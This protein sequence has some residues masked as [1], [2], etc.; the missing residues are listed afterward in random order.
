MDENTEVKLEM[1]IIFITITAIAFFFIVIPL[2]TATF[3]TASSWGSQTPIPTPTPKPLPGQSIEDA[4]KTQTPTPSPTSH[5]VDAPHPTP[6]PTASVVPHRTPV[7]APSYI[8]RLDIDRVTQMTNQ[9]SYVDQ[10]TKYIF[11][12]TLNTRTYQNILKSDFSVYEGSEEEGFEK[13]LNFGGG[14]SDIDGLVKNLK[15][16]PWV[17]TIRLVQSIPYDDARAVLIESG[18]LL[19]IKT[20]YETLFEQKGV[21]SD[22][23]VLMGYLL[24]RMGYGSAYLNFKDVNHAALGIECSCSQAQYRNPPNK[25]Y[26]YVETTR[27]CPITDTTGTLGEKVQ[28]TAKPDI[29]VMYDGNWVHVPDREISDA[30]EIRTTGWTQELAEKYGLTTS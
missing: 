12:I 27:P 18:E 29:F 11:P 8:Q 2:V 3:D 7:A 6:S 19:E 14:E 9:L 10:G 21:C 13:L 26:C 5:Q 1:G 15:R 30:E 28:L 22:K 20:P 23:T 17:H 24:M 25:C 4:Q 16:Q